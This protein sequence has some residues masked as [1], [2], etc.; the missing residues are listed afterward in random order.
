MIKK[1]YYDK[2]SIYIYTG[3]NTA[4]I[5]KKHYMENQDDFGEMVKFVKANYNK[6][7]EKA[8]A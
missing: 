6:S 8:H 7:G 3:Q 1:I 5:I 4:H 2:K